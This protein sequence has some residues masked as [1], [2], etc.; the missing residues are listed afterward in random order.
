MPTRR[1]DPTGERRMAKTDRG[2]LRLGT[3]GFSLLEMIVVLL[4]LSVV[5]AVAAPTFYR[6][7]CHHRLE[8]AARRVKQDLE[9]L[10]H[11][12]QSRSTTLGCTF[13]VAEL[14]YVL[15]PDDLHDADHGGAY[16]VALTR[17]PYGIDGLA[18]DFGDADLDSLEFN[19]FGQASASGTIV[20]SLGG[21]ERTIS[22]DAS[23]GEVDIQ[24]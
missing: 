3:A 14:S 8:S 16:V 15:D 2:P 11:T 22:V 23:S 1:H 24:P 9:H 12:A 21:D 6:S 5:A 17:E 19:G 18:I 7:L 20:V 10:R 4:I 13:D